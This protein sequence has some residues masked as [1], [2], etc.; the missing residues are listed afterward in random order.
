MDTVMRFISKVPAWEDH[1]SVTYFCQ[2]NSLWFQWSKFQGIGIWEIFKD[3]SYG[4]PW[5]IPETISNSI[6]SF[7]SLTMSLLFATHQHRYEK[8]N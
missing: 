2:V 1:S 7:P 4:C 6:T 5:T 3:L 8:E